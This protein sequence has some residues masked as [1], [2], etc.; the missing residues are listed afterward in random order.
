MV[1]CNCQLEE[2]NR[3]AVLQDPNAPAAQRRAL[4]SGVNPAV[5]E[6]IHQLLA[7]KTATQLE[8]M[9]SEIQGQIQSGQVVDL[10]Y[11]ETILKELKGFSAKVWILYFKTVVLMFAIRLVCVNATRASY[12]KS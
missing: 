5:K 1:V 8:T 9:K 4:E 7:S 3:Q 11:W 6:S 12:N 10:D 2:K